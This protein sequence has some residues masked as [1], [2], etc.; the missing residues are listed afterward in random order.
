MRT[1]ISLS[2]LLLGVTVICILLALYKPPPV[3]SSDAQVAAVNDALVSKYPKGTNFK[4]V[5]V[6]FDIFVGCKTTEFPAVFRVANELGISQLPQILKNNK[7]N[8][9]PDATDSMI[10]WQSEVPEYSIRV[11]EKYGADSGLRFFHLFTFRGKLTGYEAL[12]D[13]L[14][15]CVDEDKIVDYTQSPLF[16]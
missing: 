11:W 14:V 5:G 8:F 2:V 15:L 13:D 1:Q 6:D 7:P 9:A 4:T 16:D 3:K 12:M 10:L